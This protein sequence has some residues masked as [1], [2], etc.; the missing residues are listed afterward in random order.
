MKSDTEIMQLALEALELVEHCGAEAM[1]GGL[2]EIDEAIAE[3]KD[4]LTNGPADH[5]LDAMMFLEN[6]MD[7]R[8]ICTRAV[9][10]VPM[11]AVR[12]AHHLLQ[13]P[14]CSGYEWAASENARV[15]AR[16]AIDD[17]KWRPEA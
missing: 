10:L 4:R 9:G 15:A 11:E 7:G 13:G 12:V 17:A 3:L 2:K 1:E 8:H 5:R 16:S 6:A 14:G